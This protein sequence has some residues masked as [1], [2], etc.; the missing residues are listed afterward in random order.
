MVVTMLDNNTDAV[1]WLLET[2]C[3]LLSPQSCCLLQLQM[4]LAPLQLRSYQ[5]SHFAQ[6]LFPSNFISDLLL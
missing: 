4:Q 6:Q 1:G 5:Q 3:S 2:C